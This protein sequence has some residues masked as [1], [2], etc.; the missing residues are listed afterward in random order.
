VTVVHRAASERVN[1]ADNLE[2]IR[3]PVREQ[4]QHR[5][6]RIAAAALRDNPANPNHLPRR[7]P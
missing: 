2:A 6:E 4:L 3:G 1:E 5:S 7:T